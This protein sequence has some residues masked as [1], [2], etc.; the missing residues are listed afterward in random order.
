MNFLFPGI[1]DET[2]EDKLV[3]ITETDY[4]FSRNR[5]NGK[6]FYHMEMY[7]TKRYKNYCKS[8]ST[9]SMYV[10]SGDCR[11]KWRHGIKKAKILRY[12]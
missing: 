11:Y 3:N 12:S 7:F 1:L 6:I 8:N 10:L 5:T 4:R 2:L 9:Q